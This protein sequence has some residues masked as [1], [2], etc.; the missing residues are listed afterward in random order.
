LCTTSPEPFPNFADVAGFFFFFFFLKKNAEQDKWWG[1]EKLVIF[2]N[3]PPFTVLSLSG[4]NGRPNPF[5]FSASHGALSLSLV[6]VFILRRF[7]RPSLSPA[8]SDF[9]GPSFSTQVPKD[10]SLFLSLYAMLRERESRES[11]WEGE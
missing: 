3:F 9:P 6:G 1:G 4:T 11:L 8:T 10:F 7:W 5:L 2:P